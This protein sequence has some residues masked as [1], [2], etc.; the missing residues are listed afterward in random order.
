LTGIVWIKSKISH[1]SVNDFLWFYKAMGWAW[2]AILKLKKAMGWV[3][4]AM[5]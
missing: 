3:N 4:K 2:R 1:M 5:G